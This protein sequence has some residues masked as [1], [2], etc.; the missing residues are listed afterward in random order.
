M[1]KT[2]KEVITGFFTQEES[3]TYLSQLQLK[4]S[5]WYL[6][7]ENERFIYLYLLQY[8][9]TGHTYGYITWDIVLAN[10]NYILSILTILKAE[11]NN[12]L[13]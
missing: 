6:Q 3:F 5:N 9:K 11:E 10:N 4:V 8:V 7:F 12:F 1:K 13:T 2:R